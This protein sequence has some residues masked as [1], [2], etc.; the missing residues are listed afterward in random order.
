MSN[1]I[2]V[3]SA[4]EAKDSHEIEELHGKSRLKHQ[5]DASE[6]A[7]ITL[8]WMFGKKMRKSGYQYF[9]SLPQ[10]FQKTF[11]LWLLNIGLD[12]GA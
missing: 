6:Y 3:P 1:N 7:F 2:A 11:F 5:C 8:S 9:F 4:W 12:A 10:C